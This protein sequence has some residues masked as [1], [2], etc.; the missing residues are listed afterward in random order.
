M[1]AVLAKVRPGGQLRLSQ[2]QIILL[3]VASLFGVFSLLLN[4]FFT[5]ENL[6]N[7][8]RRVSSLG[9]LSVAMAV[10][11]LAGGMVLSLVASLGVASAVSIQLRRTELGTAMAVLVGLGIVLLMGA[12]NGFVIAFV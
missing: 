10:V 2:E 1:G 7:L 12:I 5:A 9:I 6:L 3:V 8:L 11:V 4:V